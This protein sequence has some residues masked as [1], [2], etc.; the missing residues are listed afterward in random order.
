MKIWLNGELSDAKD[1]QN[2]AQLAERYAL[3]ANSVL[4]EHNGLALHQREWAERKLS[5]DDRVEFIRV[6][7]GG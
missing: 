6:V 5:A 7:A 4:V 3:R 2:V 1:A